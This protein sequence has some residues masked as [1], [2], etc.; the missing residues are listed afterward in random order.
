MLL[1]AFPLD[2]ALWDA[3]RHALA[4]AGYR[5]ITPDLPGFG[6]SAPLD[7]EPSLALAADAVA[8]MLNHLEIE[9]AIIGGL[10]MGGYVTMQMVRR[11]PDR[12]SG[13]ILADTRASADAPEAAAG[14]MAG[15]TAVLASGMT[16]EV[17]G[18]MLPNLLGTTTHQA[19]PEVVALVRRWIMSQDPQG[20]AW[21][22]RA[23]AARTDSFDALATFA[24][25]ALLL[26]G[27]EDLICSA[28]DV[29]A[30]ADALGSAVVSTV[31]IP[32]VGHLSAV[33]DAAP[34][35]AALRG[36]LDALPG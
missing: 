3:Q 1:H 4:D 13:L 14:R 25:P 11:H 15:A 6:A 8:H 33:E 21:A 2:H 26:R 17:A 19:R 23:M 27:A 22:Q 32:G 34:V 35:T 36:W 10:S 18:S 30:M 5:V 12:I 16:A 9:R 28:A 29:E 24:G 20:V 31:E 7:Q